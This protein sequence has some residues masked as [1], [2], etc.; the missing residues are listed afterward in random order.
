MA[1]ELD[2][3]DRKILYELDLNS[4]QSYN[5]LAKKVKLSKTALLNRINNLQEEGIIKS[6]HTI[7]DTGKLG[8]IGFR[9]Y[10]R[11]QNA[12]REKEE[13]II[14]WLNE[15]EIISW[16]VSIEGDYDIGMLILVKSISEMNA[17]W[18]ELLEKYLNYIDER[19]LTIMAGV[20]YFS[21][22]YLL[23]LKQNNYEIEFATEPREVYID[24]KDK[25][26][27]KLLAGNARI[28]VIDI[29][30]NVRLTPKTVIQRIRQLEKKKIIIG[31]KTSFNMQKLGY[32]YYKIHFRLNN[33]T[34]EKEKEFRF[35][36][37]HHPNIIY[38]D[39][40]LGGDDFEIE[41]QAENN[42]KLRQIIDEIRGEFANIIKEHRVMQFYKEHKYLLLPVKI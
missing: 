13:E 40:V 33:V 20:S 16:I 38:D 34:K 42:D 37:K 24:E 17:F 25:E 35:F 7:I 8:Y 31:Y 15:K 21:R 28:S 36:V 9:L 6:F 32:E 3:K 11:L 10:I 1:I 19:L 30:S 12:S 39:K 5:S 4:R 27:L 22:A 29:A 2:L 41:I 18:K 14:K 26:I 23:G